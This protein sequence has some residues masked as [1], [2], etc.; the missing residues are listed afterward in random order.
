FGSDRG[1][2][3]RILP[4]ALLAAG[5]LLSA[6]AAKI[7]SDVTRFN[8]LTMPPG[9]ETVAV[10]AKDKTREKSMEFAQYAAEVQQRLTALGFRPPEGG[11]LPD[12]IAELDYS[13]D[14][15]PAALRDGGR[16]PVSVGMGV[17]GGSG[18]WR[19]GGV[20]VGVS[21]GFDLGGSKSG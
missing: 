5:F 14:R 9:G 3:M 13:V 17:G 4:F 21:T 8:Q 1:Y 12:I 20:G 19:G 7:S 15:G 18:G 16:S 6:C 11:N 10:I 2:F